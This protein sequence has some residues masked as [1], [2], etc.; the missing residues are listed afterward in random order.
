MKPN[1]IYLPLLLFTCIAFGVLL[2][3][4]LHLPVEKFS[5]VKNNYKTKL[6]KLLDFIDNE[7]VDDK[8]YSNVIL[9]SVN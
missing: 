6:N 1:K 5:F 2:G 4:I 3:S 8:N 7:Y 9:G